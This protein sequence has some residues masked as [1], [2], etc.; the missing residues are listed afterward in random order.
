MK[1]ISDQNTLSVVIPLHDPNSEFENYLVELFESIR[2]QSQR[3]DEVIIGGSHEPDY[4]ENI[5]KSNSDLAVLSFYLNTTRSTS[6]NLNYL[7][8]KS[9]STLTKILFQDDFFIEKESISRIKDFFSESK[10]VWM[11]T[12]SKNF[13]DLTKKFIKKVVPRISRK[14]SDG[15]NTIGSPSVI[16][17]RTKH[18]VNFNEDLIWMLDCDW[19][20]RMEHRHGPMGVLKD[21]QIA[22]RL[23]EKQATHD[24]IRYQEVESKIVKFCHRSKP[25]TSPCP[26]NN[27]GS[28]CSCL[29]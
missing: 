1:T 5:F 12:G 15:I 25:Y 18:F 24:A 4:L 28:E 22:N 16:T 9:N 23:H 19:Y 14:L 6:S 17:L 21:F 29:D 20:L 13:D 2:I 7:V 11:A 26:R 8:K 27:Y 10:S 3:P